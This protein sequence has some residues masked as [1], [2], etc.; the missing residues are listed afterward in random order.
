MDKLTLVREFSRAG[1]CLTVGRFVRE[2]P[3]FFVYNEWLGG[4]RFSP[5]QRRIG[6]RGRL[7]HTE[8]CH[9][10]TDYPKTHYPHGYMD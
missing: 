8:P 1:P 4:D 5:E 9:S 3:K 7:V 2:T 6:K 10:C